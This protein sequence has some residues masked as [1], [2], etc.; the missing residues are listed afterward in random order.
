MSV[1]IPFTEF[2]IT[3][4][5]EELAA[6]I[7][8]NLLSCFDRLSLGIETLSVSFRSFLAYGPIG[9]ASHNMLV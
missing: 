1:T 6:L 8:G 2:S 9:T 3:A 7:F 4:M 5:N